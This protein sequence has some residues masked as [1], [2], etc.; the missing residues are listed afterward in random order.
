MR[1]RASGERGDFELRRRPVWKMSAQ[2][3]L[4]LAGLCSLTGC[5]ANSNEARGDA[6]NPAAVSAAAPGAAQSGAEDAPA[7]DSTGGFDG[8]LA[9]EHVAKQV[10]F[11]PRPSGSQA[12]AQTQDYIL[13][14][15]KSGGCTTE[16]DSFNADTP[17]GRLPMK[18][19]LVKIPGDDSSIILLGTHYDTL[20]RND[21]RF[22]GANDSGS[23]T[24]VML[25]LARLLCAKHGKHPVWI[26]FFDG[27]EAM[28]K[29]SETDSRYGSRQMAARFA[30]S[31][32]ISK[33]KAFLLADMVGS[34]SLH[35]AQEAS[36]TK[37]LVDLMWAT[38]ARLGYS[39]VFV[40]TSSAAEDDHDSFLKR[41]VPSIDVIDFD[42]TRDVPFWHTAE[43]TLDKISAR[44]LATSGHVFLETVKEL[45]KQ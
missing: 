11:G 31:G 4:F 32:D 42:Q 44:S 26:A 34:R 9:F 21:I 27:E 8:K 28:K 39:D 24:A 18:N 35:F 25:E 13:A 12:I 29:W 36:S 14:Q 30:A 7:P 6:G 3:V 23:S 19:M 33:I 45:Q 43:D 5:K 41:A 17:I 40:N 38:A 1:S 37:S 16:V 20:L 10:G 22:V 2:A 15:L